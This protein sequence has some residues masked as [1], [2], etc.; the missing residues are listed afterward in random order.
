MRR[1]L[2]AAAVAAWTVA[3]ARA[4]EPTDE[5]VKNEN[6][7]L[8][9]TRTVKASTTRFKLSETQAKTLADLLDERT[10]GAQAKADIINGKFEEVIDLAS[11]GFEYDPQIFKKSLD[12]FYEDLYAY[13]AQTGDMIREK[14]LDDNQR[15][16]FDIDRAGG[17]GPL[18]GFN[19]RPKVDPAAG[20]TVRRFSGKGLQEEYWAA[21]V[22]ALLLRVKATDPQKLES[23]RHLDQAVAA[24]VEY[25]KSKTKEYTAAARATAAARKKGADAKD[26]AEAEKLGLDLNKPLQQ[27]FI[28][29][30]RDLYDLL[31]E[32]QRKLAGYKRPA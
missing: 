32:E 12:P 8:F 2:V 10:R 21:W 16:L 19:E 1:I 28:K 6:R 13:Q 3:A 22:D 31:T 18:R 26:R 23:V 5:D 14:I 30:Q 9:V 11:K 20:K 4:Q 27:M 29:L 17:G 7:R 24:A 15:R 25:R